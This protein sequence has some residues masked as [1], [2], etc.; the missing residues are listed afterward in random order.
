MLNIGDIG[1]LKE[2]S[3]EPRI[4]RPSRL[5][6]NQDMAL[7]LYQMHIKDR[8]LNEILSDE[9][10]SFLLKES[11]NYD[12]KNTAGMGFAILSEDT[13][14]V[15]IWNKENPIL[16]ETKLYSYNGNHL[17][18]TIKKLDLNKPGTGTF[19]VFE[20]AIA[21]HEKNAWLRFLETPRTGID[22]QNYL[23]DLIDGEIL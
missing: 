9:A 18:N 5:I 3:H 8:P 10:K 4:A 20:M 15:G 22:K 7:K 11:E 23:N 19:C 14:N 17:K 2:Y 1:E 13:L 21:N 6:M 16:L 12:L